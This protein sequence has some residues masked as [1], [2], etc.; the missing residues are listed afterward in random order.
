MTEAI[1][2]NNPD[3]DMQIEFLC[4]DTIN[5]WRNKL[6][7]LT[8]EFKLSRLERRIIIYIGRHPDIRQADL[9]TIMDVEPQSLTR[10]LDKMEKKSWILKSDDAKDKRAKCLNLTQEG[11]NRLVDVLKI[12]ERI[13]PKI[14]EN[15][16]HEEKCMVIKTL[17]IIKKNL[18]KI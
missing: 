12:S 9:A 16:S 14:L 4:I 1:H 5:L 17:N 8:K 3:I 15:I 18:T 13:R 2:L 11:N 7:N 10:A 6:G